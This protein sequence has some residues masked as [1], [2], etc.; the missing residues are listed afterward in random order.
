MSDTISP[1]LNQLLTK[2]RN[3]YVLHLD[4]CCLRWHVPCTWWHESC[5]VQGDRNWSHTIL[6]CS[7]RHCDTLWRRTSKERGQFVTW[8]C[9]WATGC[10]K[11]MQP[12]M[13]A[14]TYSD[15]WVMVIFLLCRRKKSLLMRLVMMTLEAAENNWLKLKRSV[16]PIHKYIIWL[17]TI[18]FGISCCHIFGLW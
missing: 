14:F 10:S 15:S 6:H 4:A 12:S 11:S 9:Y 5:R 7:T 18:D 17:H 1:L 16:S 8:D 13:Q 3:L 2:L